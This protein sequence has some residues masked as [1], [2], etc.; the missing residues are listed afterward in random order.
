V[1]ASIKNR[2]VFEV[3][4]GVKVFLSVEAGV[5]REGVPPPA[6]PGRGAEGALKGRARDLKKV[7]QRIAERG[8]RR[9]EGPPRPSTVGLAAAGLRDHANPENLVWIF[10]T[11]RSGSTWLASMMSEL[12]RHA[13]WNEPLVGALFGNFYYERAGHRANEAGRNFILGQ[14]YKDTWVRPMRDLVL[15]GAVA[16]YPELAEGG[17]VVIKEP[18]GSVGAPLLMEA[19]PES[20]MI[21]LVRDPR[22]VVASSIDSRKEGSW[23]YERRQKA[24]DTRVKGAADKIVKEADQFARNRAKGYLQAIG[25]AKQAYDAHEGPK[26]LVRY[27]ELR[28]DAL[29]TMRR[30]YAELG[31]PADDGALARAVEKHAWENIPEGEKGEGKFYRKASPGGWRE[32]LT[33]EQARIV[34][35]V[36]APLLK[37][38]YPA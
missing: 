9:L 35:E 13:V 38:L 20:R 31:I 12:E 2:L 14:A 7:G 21:L 36:T 28:A 23:R 6:P 22:D 1:P 19:L 24:G 15:G 29:G 18:N 5:G 26:A 17:Y 34:E 37:E 16:R 25:N 10:G 8:R 4:R 27:E 11:A 3:A 33:P 30:L 32:D